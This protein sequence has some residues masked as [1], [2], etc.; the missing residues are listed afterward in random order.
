MRR[1]KQKKQKKMIIVGSLCLLLCLCVGYAAFSTQISLTAKG[2]IK[3]KP[4]CEVNG[5]KIYTVTEGDGLY[6]DEYE[7]GKC[8]YKGTDPNNYFTYNNETWRIVSIEPDGWVKLILIPELPL[9]YVW[10]DKA[11]LGDGS[12]DWAAPADINIDLTNEWTGFLNR[13]WAIGSVTANNNDLQGQINDEKS[14]TWFGNVGLVTASEVL[15]AN[16]NMV[17]CEV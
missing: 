8:T 13:D 11:M 2:N 10:D 15:R 4:N 1:R 17:Q 7:D 16:S 12:N 14:K 5:T 3:E 9:E 6:M